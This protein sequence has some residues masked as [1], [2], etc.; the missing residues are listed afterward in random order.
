MTAADKKIILEKGSDYRL[1]LKIKQDDGLLDRNLSG[2][3]TR[4][5][6]ESDYLDKA[7]GYVFQIFHKNGLRYDCVAFTTDVGTEVK[8]TERVFDAQS[9]LSYEN[10]GATTVTIGVDT[11]YSIAPWETVID[12]VKKVDIVKTTANT[13]ATVANGQIVLDPSSGIMFKNISGSAKTVSQITPSDAFSWQTIFPKPGIIAKRFTEE[14]SGD[15]LKNG[16]GTVSIDSAQ[17]RALSTGN[18]AIDILSTSFNYAY[19]LTLY[20]N[21]DG[22]CTQTINTRSTREMRVLRGK[23]AVRL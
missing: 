22:I 1:I 10:I 5:K 3:A 6:N 15:D 2:S 20:E 11:N 18:T 8:P 21:F 16:A 17:T 7:W 13:A 23:L 19:T 4:N 9:S 12:G 14:Y